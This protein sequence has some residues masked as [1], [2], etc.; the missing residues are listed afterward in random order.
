MQRA[1]DDSCGGVDVLH[2]HSFVAVAAQP[3]HPAG[4]GPGV[5]DPVL[6]AGTHAPYRAQHVNRPC[7]GRHTV[8]KLQRSFQPSSPH[9]SAPTPIVEI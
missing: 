2:C 7:V 5:A 4:L 3:Q 8:K 6:K 1:D 9:M